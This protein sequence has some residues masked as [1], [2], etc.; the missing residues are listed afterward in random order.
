MLRVGGKL[1]FVKLVAEESSQSLAEED[2][3]YH[4]PPSYI[5]E[6]Q[7]DSHGDVDHQLCEVV[8]GGHIVKPVSKG[9]PVVTV[10]D[11]S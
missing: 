10:N 9:D 1:A 7:G 6:P 11:H 4:Q 3:R 2:V 5:M 8:R